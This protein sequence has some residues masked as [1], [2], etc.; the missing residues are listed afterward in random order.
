MNKKV[1]IKEN[2]YNSWEKDMK[3]VCLS[4]SDLK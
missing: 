3:I 4:K 1:F 2:V